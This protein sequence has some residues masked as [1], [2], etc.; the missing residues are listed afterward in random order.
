[1]STETETQVSVEN[2]GTAWV[3]RVAPANGPP[4]VFRCAT[5]LM[6]RRL[7]T[8]LARMTPSRRAS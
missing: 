1:M 3:V 4:Q 2:D 7:M 5:E 8:A 6:A